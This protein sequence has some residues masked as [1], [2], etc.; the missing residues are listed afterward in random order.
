MES[1]R[2]LP[3]TEPSQSIYIEQKQIQIEFLGEIN[4]T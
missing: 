3:L 1:R 4:Y 2:A